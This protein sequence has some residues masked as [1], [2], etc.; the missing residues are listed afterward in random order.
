MVTIQVKEIPADEE[1]AQQENGSLIEDD[2]ASKHKIKKFVMDDQEYEP[3]KAVQRGGSP[4]FRSSSPA[5]AQNNSTPSTAPS[6]AP[7]EDDLEALNLVPIS[8]R[9]QMY[10]QHAAKPEPRPEPT[11]KTSNSS[12]NINNYTAN[13]DNICAVC[14]KKVYLM[15]KLTADKQIFH[16]TCFKCTKCRRTLDVR[17]YSVNEGKFYCKPH[18]MELFRLRGGDMGED[19]VDANGSDVVR[20]EDKSEDGI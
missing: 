13:G 20:A 9:M 17:T 7:P 12:W 3:P 4:A 11:K 18:F 14:N 2:K 16:K 8:Q 15:D 1:D 6:Q 5:P 10:Q 19:R